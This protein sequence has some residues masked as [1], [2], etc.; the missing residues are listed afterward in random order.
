M[1]VSGVCS[2]GLRIVV[3]PAASAGSDLL[4]R[5]QNRVV[6]G[7]DQCGDAHRLLDHQAH[8]LG[9][10][11][12]DGTHHL[13][14]PAG[15]VLEH[16]GGLVDVPNGVAKGLAIVQGLQ[17]G[18]PVTVAADDLG[19]P[20]EKGGPVAWRR[21]SAPASVLEG[22]TGGGDS[23][24]CVLGSGRR[25]LVQHLA[26]G[27]VERLEVLPGARVC[28]FPIDVELFHACLR[29]AYSISLRR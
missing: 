18:E 15:V 14:R 3:Q 24:I 25:D 2:A 12:W 28:P 23:S 7:R 10:D 20:E 11:G 22:A 26:G 4:T 16:V 9:P 8:R 21:L 27:R 5:H 29:W 17:L 6:P 19:H 13:G 1:A